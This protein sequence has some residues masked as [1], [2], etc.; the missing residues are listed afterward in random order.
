MNDV[1]PFTLRVGGAASDAPRI[2]HVAWSDVPES[3]PPSF[4]FSRIHLRRYVARQRML[5]SR[6]VDGI[7]LGATPEL[8]KELL[9]VLDG[10]T[11]G[12]NKLPP[13]SPQIKRRSRQ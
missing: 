11:T 9:A 5:V 1:H 2:H 3:V 10:E 12:V 13:V 7:A 6:R 8:Q 4:Q